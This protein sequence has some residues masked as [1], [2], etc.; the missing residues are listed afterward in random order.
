MN[1]NPG[2]PKTSNGFGQNNVTIFTVFL[3]LKYDC[4]NSDM[5]S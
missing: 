4:Y 3:T 5:S 1:W 2:L